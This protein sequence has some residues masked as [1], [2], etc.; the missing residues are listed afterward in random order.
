MSPGRALRATLTILAAA[1]AITCAALSPPVAAAQGLG[2]G[3]ITGTVRDS[4]GR[5]I[6]GTSITLTNERTGR[7]LFLRS[8]RDGRFGTGFIAPGRYRG[9]F[10]SLN[11]VPELLGDIV[12]L[13]G[14]RVNVPVVLT[15]AREGNP[16]PAGS[17][18]I[19]ANAGVETPPAQWFTSRGASVLPFDGLGLNA[20][21][22]LTSRAGA[23]GEVEGLPAALSTIVIDGIPAVQRA[24][25]L[26][27][28]ARASSFALSGLDLVELVTDAID[29][30]W[31]ASGGS[32][33]SAMTRQGPRTLGGH[34]FGDWSGDA[35]GSAAD[36]ASFQNYRIGGQLGGPIVPD[37]ANFIVGAEFLRSEVPFQ[38]IWAPDPETA[39]LVDALGQQFGDGLARYTQPTT[40]GLER[41]SGFGRLDL[42]LADAHD[43]S[44]RGNAAVL[45]S[46]DAIGPRDG[47]LLGPGAAPEA[48]DLFASATL[49]SRISED[50]LMLNEVNAGFELSRYSR[51]SGSGGQALDLP[52]TTIATSGHDFGWADDA[53]LQSDLLN[54][55]LRETVHD[56]RGSHRLKYGFSGMLPTY[57]F[58]YGRLK[59]GEFAFASVDDFLQRRGA[60]RRME[61]SSAPT[62]LTFRHFSFFAQDAWTP[63][64]SLE[65]TA[66]LRYSLTRMPDSSGVGLDFTFLGL[67]GIRNTHTGFRHGQFEPMFGL[68]WSPEGG[69]AW[70]VR[71]NV[72][73]HGNP[74]SPDLVGEVFSNT[75]QVNVFAG[76]GNLGTWPDA[77]DTSVA[78]LRGNTLSLLGPK[79]RGARTT[80]VSGSISR[81]LG[82]FATLS[83]A[84]VYRQ[85]AFLPRRRDVNLIPE[86][87]STDQHGRHVFGELVNVGGLLAPRPHTNRRLIEYDRIWAIESTGEST[88]QGLT[89]SLRRP[90]LQSFA[91]HGA[92]TYSKT[93]DNWLLGNGHDPETQISPFPDSLGGVDWTTGRSDLD[94]PHRVVL[95]AEFKVPGVYGPRIGGLYRFQSGYPF[96]P[97]FRDGVDVNGDGSARNDPAFID[98]QIPGTDELLATW[99]CLNAL[100]AQFAT[101][102]ACRAP[103][104]HSLDARVSLDIVRSDRYAAQVV[105]DGLNLLASDAGQVDRALYLIDSAASLGGNQSTG[106]VSIPFIINPEFGQVRTR[107]APQRMIRL[108]LRV[109]Y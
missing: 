43:L 29:V 17:S 85:S 35:L 87:S 83:V 11:Y 45:P 105:V 37:T 42:R 72:V 31:P 39:R 82:N 97:G 95:G 49:L 30:E 48:R 7:Q 62:K 64:A 52:S 65:V 26:G 92:Y 69:Q 24:G 3:I 15:R 47:L 77:P 2:S 66:G 46:L 21:T 91:L 14:Q 73:V 103:N 79:F 5:P 28:Q 59:A 98:P 75:G 19:M 68:T 80:R 38:Q 81:A 109:S 54:F 89:F 76:V 96:T 99:P 58:S 86:Q 41:I 20:A 71:A 12:I 102:N 32:F 16:R 53:A 13:P 88:Y 57:E 4:I 44:I 34:F 74:A 8:A 93:E 6:F 25:A 9:L 90:L 56:Q 27:T 36:A 100:A 108:G 33:I 94:V 23:L 18:E 55:Y 40:A 10:E 84:G 78:G 1:G 67:T 107:Y 60:Y 70:V 101:R 61:T 63:S 104:L 22:L 106:T 50:G 51:D